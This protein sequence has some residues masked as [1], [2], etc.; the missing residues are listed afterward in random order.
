MALLKN[1]AKASAIV[2]ATLSLLSACGGGGSDGLASTATSLTAKA[3]AGDI[4]PDTSPDNSVAWVMTYF[5]PNQDL[6]N[7]SLHLA[8]STDGLNWSGLNAGKPVYQAPTT[9]QGISGSGHIRD[10]FILRKNDGKFV[11]I[12]TDW[13]LAVNDSNYWNR[14]SSRIFVADS[15]DLITFT[16]PRFLTMASTLGANTQPHAW[17]PE[18]YY[19]SD[20]RKYAIV[21]SGN[22][23]RGRTYVSYTKD[24]NSLVNPTPEVLFDPGYDE[25]DA[26][27]VPYNG[28]NYLF[29][30]DETGSGKDIQ[31][32]KSSGAGLVA[33]SFTRISPNYLTRGANQSTM[34]GTEGPLVIKIP[35]QQK[36]YIYADYY[37]NG[38]VFGCWTTTNLDADP[39]SWT[40]LTNG[41]DFKLPEGVRHANTVR[42]TQAQLDALKARYGVTVPAV[43]TRIKTTYSEGGTPFYAAHAWFHGIITTLNDT[44]NGQLPADFKWRAAPGLA[45]PSDPNLVS[46]EATGFPGRYL[47]IDSANPTRWPTGSS[48]TQANRGY[49]LG[50]IATADKHHLTWVDPLEDSTTFKSDATFRKVPALNGDASMVSL[51]W[52]GDTTL[53]LR[54]MAYQLMGLPST[55]NV[56][57]KIDASFTLE[58]Q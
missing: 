2:V 1:L 54:H 35:G 56:Q 52:Y 53:Y 44:N 20:R 6:A 29:Y 9:V 22:A 42:V 8:F 43:T 25:I 3:G 4:A 51:Q 40:K 45:D 16:N 33:G 19:D 57:Q 48:L 21:W 46:F 7:D 27:V 49:G 23:D 14:P 28:H 36:W 11:Y 30:K 41:V 10:P 32:A 34:Q 5:G 24:F 18:T 17:A 50:W 15:D 31:V 58:T 26:T 55:A 12:A 38:G 39:A 37:G 13:T 47:R